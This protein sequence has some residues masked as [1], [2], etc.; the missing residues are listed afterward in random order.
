MSFLRAGRSHPNAGLQQLG[1]E[2]KQNSAFCKEIQKR[3]RCAAAGLLLALAGWA[4]S[5]AAC[6][7]RRTV[8]TP[9]H[10]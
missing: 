8:A 6:T 9:V 10:T 2:G 3:R 5:K 4:R 7:G 1:S